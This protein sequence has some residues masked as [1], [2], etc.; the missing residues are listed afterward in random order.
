M[1]PK[2]LR[3]L[4]GPV[5][6][7][8][9]VATVMMLAMRCE[10]MR[11]LELRLLDYRYIAR[12]RFPLHAVAVHPDIAM[13]LVDEETLDQIEDPESLWF[14]L[15]GRILGGLDQAG[16]KAVGIDAVI[17]YL[18][19]EKFATVGP[20]LLGIKDRLVFISYLSQDGRTG[21]ARLILPHK[22]LLALGQQNV[23]L[24]NL[25]RDLDGIPRAQA[26]FPVPLDQEGYQDWSLFTPRLAEI[27]SGRTL[28]PV[29]GTFG[30]QPLPLL[31]PD[32]PRILINYAGSSGEAFPHYSFAEVLKLVEKG[33]TAELKRRF[34]GKIVLIGPGSKASQ[35]ITE[36]PYSALASPTVTK[37]LTQSGTGSSVLGIYVQASILNTLLTGAWLRKAPPAVNLALLFTFCIA[38]ALV[39]YRLGALG[40]V[41]FSLACAVVVTLACAWAFSGPGIWIEATPLLASIPL[42]WGA[43]YSYRYAVEEREKNFVR[44]TFGRYVSPD[45]MEELLDDPDKLSLDVG[46]RREI[47]VLFADINGFTTVSESR[48]PEEVIRMLNAYFAEMTRII[49]AH[50]GTI[51]KFVGD[52]LMVIYD[53]PPQARQSR[54]GRGAD[55]AGHGG[56]ARGTG[57]AGS[58]RRR[59]CH[60]GRVLSHQGRRAHGSRHHGQHRVHRAH[61]LHHHRRHGEPDVAHHEHD[62]EPGREYPVE[63]DDLREGKGDGWGGVRI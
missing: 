28:D 59:P 19:L 4:V 5:V 9:V 25:T 48:S 23:A 22:V 47:T 45:V 52:E 51:G 41:A 58:P 37:G 24:A 43:T 60:H 16:V 39:V 36:T 33:D 15:Y 63:R 35:D 50:Q 31:A 2:K 34:G 53:A 61:G 42:L 10:F 40:G 49:F 1:I 8:L 46:E 3:G 7:G 55:C 54:A 13:I 56:A 44:E 20:A 30:D 57:P 18:D 12:E 32:D 21:Q 62:Q 29:R 14:P 38:V 11:K 27:Y 6:V 17:S 26:V